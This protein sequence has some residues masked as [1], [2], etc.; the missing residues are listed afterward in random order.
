MRMTANTSRKVNF[1]VATEQHCRSFGELSKLT[2]N[3]SFYDC[4]SPRASSM[5]KIMKDLKLKSHTKLKL[6][7]LFKDIM[8]KDEV[9][10]IPL[11][12]GNKSHMF[13]KSLDRYTEYLNT[14]LSKVRGTVCIMNEKLY[15]NDN[16]DLPYR[17]EQ[18]KPGLTYEPH[19]HILLARSQCEAN[20]LEAQKTDGSKVCLIGDPSIKANLSPYKVGGKLLMVTSC[21]PTRYKSSGKVIDEMLAHIE[22]AVKS[23]VGI[24]Q[25][26]LKPHPG[27][28]DSSYVSR[29]IS[30]CRGLGIKFSEIDKWALIEDIIPTVDFAVVQSSLS[31]HFV[32]R[33]AGVES[34]YYLSPDERNEDFDFIKKT[35]MPLCKLNHKTIG[36]YDAKEYDRWIQE[37]FLLDGQQGNRFLD[38]IQ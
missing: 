33:Q 38:A 28:M 6:Q 5:A 36:K 12:I 8:T 37:T 25:L 24:K 21:D 3:F 2:D 1:L 10:V 18:T 32:L 35:N 29:V 9:F 11:M 27:E 34:F 13:F 16:K 15:H 7:T 17:H 23:G 22:L 19:A 31:T 30:K 14:P 26:L 4:P 20:V